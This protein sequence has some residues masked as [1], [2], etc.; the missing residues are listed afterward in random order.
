VVGADRVVD[1]NQEDFVQSCRYDLMLDNAG[2]RSLSDCRRVLASNGTLV[3]N[4]E[5]GG[6]FVGFLA[7]LLKG[8]LVSRFSSK[9]VVFHVA[10]ISQ[11]DLIVLQE[12]IEA[13]KAT[14][15]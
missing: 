15:C 11:R 9:K 4:A 5:P 7:R 10:K 6:S 1:Y 13:R 2:N 8:L 3:L 14:R 12:F